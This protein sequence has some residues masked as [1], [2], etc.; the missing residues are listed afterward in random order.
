MTLYPPLRIF[1]GRGVKQCKI[2]ANF[3][4]QRKEAKRGDVSKT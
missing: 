1:T 2:W 4:L 3:G